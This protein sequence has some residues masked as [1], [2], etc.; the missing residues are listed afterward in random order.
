MDGEFENLHQSHIGLL[1]KRRSDQPKEQLLKDVKGLLRDL[2]SAGRNIDDES[3]R[4]RL[5]SY[6]A[7]WG[8]FI[9]ENTG[10]YPDTV[11]E[12]ADEELSRP[13]ADE[14]TEKKNENHPSETITETV[15]EADAGEAPVVTSKK[16][17]GG[18][19]LLGL[20]LV[21]SAAIGYWAGEWYGIVMMTLT[22]FAIFVGL[23]VLISRFLLPLQGT[24]QWEQAFRSLVAFILGTNYP[25]YV[26][27]GGNI[28]ERVQGNPYRRFFAGPGIVLSG[29][30]HLSVISDGVS[31][32]RIG[33]PG[34][35]FTERFERLQQVI[36]L[37]PQVRTPDVKAMTRDGVYIKVTVSVRFRLDVHGRDLRIGDSF[38]VDTDSVQKALASQLVDEGRT[39]TWDEL[40]AIAAIRIVR[41][42][43]GSYRLDELSE[44]FDPS[45][46]PRVTIQRSLVRRLEEEMRGSGIEVISGG[47]GNLNPV[48]DQVIDRRIESWRAGWWRKIAG[49]LAEGEANALWEEERARAAAHSRFI[50]AMV[51]TMEKYPQVSRTTLANVAALRFVDALEEL[52]GHPDIQESLSSEISETIANMRHLLAPG[53]E[54]NGVGE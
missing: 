10:V 35:N 47:I 13:P 38:P 36:D 4:R 37:R 34:L 12:P 25:Y 53:G 16:Q 29:P 40:V 23:L 24:G 14:S 43:V 1:Q 41:E 7:Y 20:W 3:Q 11:L 39:R 33:T 51:T 28:V 6:A 54:E 31:F 44:P 2:R 52:A 46:D 49:V 15:G 30:A 18:K 17:R 26:V 48:D 27:E 8:S 5:E 45:K 22:S 19:L 9:F 50:A 32:G 42:I 21:A